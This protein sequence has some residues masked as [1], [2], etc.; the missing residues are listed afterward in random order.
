MGD[1]TVELL[2]IDKNCCSGNWK[3]KKRT[4]RT[5]MLVGIILG[6]LYG[7]SLRNMFYG[8][9]VIRAGKGTIRAE[10]KVS[11]RFSGSIN[12][13]VKMNISLMIFT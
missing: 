6:T 5:I 7:S 9:G 11:N 10:E 4:K 12:N 2:K 3:W 13:I 1:I 8:K